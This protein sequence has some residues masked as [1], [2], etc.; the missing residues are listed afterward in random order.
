MEL[1]SARQESGL[2]EMLAET[3]VSIRKGGWGVAAYF[4]LSLQLADDHW[5][6]SHRLQVSLRRNILLASAQGVLA[7][8]LCKKLH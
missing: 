1:L 7:G 4:G 6:L 5:E 8:M 3:D 2:F